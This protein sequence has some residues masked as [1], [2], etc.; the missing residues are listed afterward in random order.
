MLKP[1]VMNLVKRKAA[2]KI[3]LVS[4]ENIICELSEVFPH[5]FFGLEELLLLCLKRNNQFPRRV[6]ASDFHG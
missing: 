1:S 5:F 2:L 6:V 4:S 3:S